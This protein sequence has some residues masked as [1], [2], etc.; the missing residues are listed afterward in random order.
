M[1]GAKLN[2]ELKNGLKK[3]RIIGSLCPKGTEKRQAKRRLAGHEELPHG[4]DC[5]DPYLPF[6]HLVRRWE[7]REEDWRGFI[8]DRQ[9]DGGDGGKD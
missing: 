4:S 7:D 8:R 3:L 2:L 6:L 9:E 5:W 1:R